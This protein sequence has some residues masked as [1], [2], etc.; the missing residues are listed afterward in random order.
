MDE[1]HSSQTGEAAK[2]LKTALA[3]TDEILEE[4]A[5]AE[6]EEEEKRPDEEDKLIAE[7]AAQGQHKNLSFFAFTATP[8]DKTLQMFGVKQPD[9]TFKAFHLY[10]MRQAIDEGFILD[11]LKNYMTYSMYYRIIKNIPHDPELDSAAGIKAIRRFESL[12]PHNLAQKTAIMVEHFRNLRP[13]TRSAAEQRRWLSPPPVCTLSGIAL[14]FSATSKTR[15]T[16]TL[17]CWSPSP[18]K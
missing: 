3:N 2:K 15:D 12:H 9:G 10:S 17:M 1:A 11:V 7:I 6:L 18:A 4:Y 5:K 8:K 13:K 16:P 14:S